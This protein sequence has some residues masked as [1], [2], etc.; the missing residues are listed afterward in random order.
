[1]GDDFEI[2]LGAEFERQLALIPKCN[3]FKIPP[4][5]QADG[6]RCTGWESCEM[7]SG[8]CRVLVKG[9]SARVVLDDPSTGKVFAEA[10]LDNANALEPVLDSRRFFV[11]RVVNGARHAFI[12]I[13]FNER[14]EAFDFKLACEDSKKVTDEFEASQAAASAPPQPIK[15][16]GTDWSLQ[17][18]QKIQINAEG[19]PATRKKR[20]IAPGAFRLNP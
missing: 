7:W 12:G 2:D 9:K 15:S 3:V 10:P 13:G 4:L 16:S 18:G 8:R 1:M 6:Y 11:L 5:N 14:N 17:P 19:K 20:E